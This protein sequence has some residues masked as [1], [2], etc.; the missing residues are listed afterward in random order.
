MQIEKGYEYG[1]IQKKILQQIERID[2]GRIFTFRDLSFE[3]EKTANV[4]VLLSE[5]SRKGVLVRV[6]K[7]AYYRPKKSVLGLGKLPVYQDEQFR[8]LTENWTA[9]SRGLTSITKWG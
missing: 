3:T 2:A 5:Q 7:G 8:Y 4:A 6:E 9:I 1:F